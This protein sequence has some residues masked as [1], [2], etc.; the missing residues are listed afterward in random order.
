M[1][2]N[3]IIF[4]FRAVHFVKKLNIHQLYTLKDI[5]NESIKELNKYGVSNFKDIKYAKKRG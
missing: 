4:R 1:K 2:N 3:G 5:T